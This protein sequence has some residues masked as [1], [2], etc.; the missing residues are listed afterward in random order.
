MAS[1]F[2]TIHPAY[3]AVK[4]NGNFTKFSPCSPLV[5]LTP[6]PPAESR[7]TRPIYRL[8]PFLISSRLSFPPGIGVCGSLVHQGRSRYSLP[9]VRSLS[10]LLRPYRTPPPLSKARARVF[11]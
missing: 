7:L 1:K 5:L 9:P 11:N 8:I 10:M 3:N 4:Y 6:T 2:G